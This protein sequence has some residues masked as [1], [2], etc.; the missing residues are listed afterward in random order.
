MKP[1]QFDYLRAG[2]IE[3]VVSHLETYGDRA[4][5]MA[6]GQTL[7]P[8]LNFRLV[9]PELIIDI[10]GIAPLAHIRMSGPWVEIGA[11]VTQSSL[12]DWSDLSREVPLVA[13]AL[14]WVGHF[15]T[16][17]RGTVCG[18]IA[19][20]DP[21]SELPL[22]LAV[23]GGAIDLASK[24][25]T[26]TL[27]VSEFQLGMLT[28]ARAPDELI[29]S[30]RFPRAKKGEGYVFREVARRHGDFAIVSLAGMAVA[31]QVVLGVGGVAGSP[32][33]R[34]FGTLKDAALDDA[35]NAFAWEM[36]G[37]DDVHATARY[38]RDLVRMLGKQ[39]IEEARACLS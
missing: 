29:T 30:V 15:Q 1:A 5:I 36:G 13:A 31:G 16:R 14:P 18:S 20:A 33:V 23:L 38:R 39:V 22:V 2:S 17:N 35:L 8:M 12:L 34:A 26:R 21:S 10:T 4:R 28:T 11:A 6:G 7:M 24:R 32:T 9:E 19:H 3:E 37:H 25:G 27:K